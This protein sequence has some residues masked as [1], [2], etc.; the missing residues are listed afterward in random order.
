MFKI[1][2]FIYKIFREYNNIIINLVSNK[3]FIEFNNGYGASIVDDLLHGVELGVKEKVG[4]GWR[5]THDTPITTD[6]IG[7]IENY[8]ELKDY[9]IQI[10]NL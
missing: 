4:D 10:E 7:Y 3:I 6:V 1:D 9:L 2:D 5:L 8:S